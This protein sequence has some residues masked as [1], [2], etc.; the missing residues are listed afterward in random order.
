MRT[1]SNCIVWAVLLYLRR[2]RRGREGYLM[3]R[4]SRWGPFP[5]MLY[6]ERRAD[7]SVRVVGYRPTDPKPRGC[8]PPVFEG[9][10]K[11]GDF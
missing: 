6:G 10:S 5:H 4:A 1:R 7:G 8:P 3:V 9:R 2:R 11:W